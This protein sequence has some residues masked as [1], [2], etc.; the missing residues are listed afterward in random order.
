MECG[1]HL[2]LTAHGRTLR[3]A[4]RGPSEGA[5]FLDS[6]LACE[7]LEQA[8]G[9]TLPDQGWH[10]GCCLD[11]PFLFLGCEVKAA[12]RQYP[13][14]SGLLAAAPWGGPGGP[15][16]WVNALLGAEWPRGGLLLGK[17][18]PEAHRV[19]RGPQG[20]CTLQPWKPVLD[21]GLGARLSALGEVLW[22]G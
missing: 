13:G 16:I 4:C 5:P 17:C 8:W 21:P 15:G 1:P 10:F 14:R 9:H 2:S 7:R 20:L 22:D 3:T 12:L 6:P 19:A 18:W 11:S